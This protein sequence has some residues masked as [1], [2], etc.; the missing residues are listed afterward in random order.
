MID[1][2]LKLTLRILVLP[3][4]AS[5]IFIF[6]PAQDP[7]NT[8]SQNKDPKPTQQ[9]KD[10]KPAQ[11]QDPK[12]MPTPEI[13]GDETIRIDNTLIG[14]PVSVTDAQGIPIK[15]LKMEDFII[16]EDGVLQKIDT[17]GEP[18][19]TPLELALLFDVSKS[20]RA[21]FD[22]QREA[23][24]RFLKTVLKPSDMISVFTIGTAPGVSVERTGNLENTIRG[25][26]L[27]EPKEDSTAFFDTVAKSI[28]YLEDNAVPG[29][30]QVI[31]T[32]SDGE[33]NNSERYKL[34][35]T[36][37]LVQQS[38]NIL[39]YSINPSGPSIRLNKISSQGHDNM[40]QIAQVTGG[41]AFNPDKL[42][43]LPKVFAQITNELQA[44][45]LLN[46]YPSNEATDGKYR[47]I[48]VRMK[49]NPTMRIRA[50][51]GYYGPKN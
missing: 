6:A 18:G 9:K 42:D 48:T 38:K 26:M 36:L 10:S 3:V 15:D 45:Y 17:I 4:V 43:D 31:L 51:D 32:L 27:I 21:K 24:I 16:E 41:L 44:Q 22:F 11:E 13:Q 29:V 1:S 25:T 33:D 14:V 7:V 47:K 35:D 39:F 46:Y 49:N 5:L 37:R 34:G 23:A 40:V 12:K 19:K 20:L 2:T 30:R 8:D 28:K 50:R